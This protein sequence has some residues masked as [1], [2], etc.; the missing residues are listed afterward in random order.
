MNRWILAIM[1]AAVL[2]FFAACS[3]NSN[4]QAAPAEQPPVAADAKDHGSEA[5]GADMQGFA[6]TL[7]PTKGNSTSGTVMLMS[8]AGGVHFSGVIS[9]LT[10]GPHG[11]HI[12]EIGDCSAPDGSSA[13]G[14]FN[15]NSANHGA[16]NTIPHHAGDLGNIVAG[17]D[18]RAELNVHA[19]DLTLGPGA[20]SVLGKSIIIHAGADDFK[21]QPTGNSGARVACAV[22]QAPK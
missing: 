6:V 2:L 5:E 15:P 20:N 1:P 22:L 21:T 7:E 19:S 3:Q 17:A 12:H 9:G 14:H 10:P 8:M 13:G 18:G 11:V 4:Q 16:P